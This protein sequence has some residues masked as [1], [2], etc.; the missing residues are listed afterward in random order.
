MNLNRN[1]VIIVAAAVPAVAG[2]AL[3]I[4][5]PASAGPA[6]LTPLSC[7]ASMSNSHPA[8]HTTTVVRVRTAA[9]VEVFTVAYYKTVNRAYFVTASSAGRANVAYYIS[10]ATPGRKVPVVVTVVRGHGANSCSTSFTPKR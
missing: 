2:I 8:D 10:G 9:S 7:T 4:A 6:A 1:R 5:G 3:G